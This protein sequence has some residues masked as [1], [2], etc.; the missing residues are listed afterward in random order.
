MSGAYP[1]CNGFY[2]GGSS[3]Y[4]KSRTRKKSGRD[5]RV[6]TGYG[7]R[8]K[9]TACPE[10]KVSQPD[11]AGRMNIRWVSSSSTALSPRTAR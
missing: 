2:L 11:Q 4:L 5:A 10:H 7:V 3:G 1:V 8:E 9:G 6:R